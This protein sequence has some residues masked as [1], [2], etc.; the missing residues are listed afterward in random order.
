MTTADQNF[1]LPSAGQS[2]WDSDL[3]GNFTIIGRGYH[4]LGQ[5]GLDVDTGYIVTVGSDGFYRPYDPNSLDNRPHAYAYKAVDSGEQDTFLL[6]GMVRS[7]G[8]NTLGAI[9]GHIVFGSPTTPGMIV[10]SYSG[11]DRPAG[12]A[13]YEDGFFFDPGRQLFPEVIT[14][15]A[16]I[17]AVTGSLHLF[18]L[19]GGAAGFIRQIIMIGDSSDLTELQLWS[20]SA[21]SA[22]LYETVSG[23]VTVIGSFLDQAGLPFFNTDATTISGKVYG[24]LQ[25]MSDASV[26]SADVGLS[27]VF[28][29]FR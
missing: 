7:L 22:P 10:A 15:S 3:N 23:G 19:D 29:R 11:A 12:V 16:A 25:V 28:E 24:T 6:R 2:D 17:N 20:N 9:P 18:I 21:R 5:A 4:V 13:T 26:S 8:I 14:D 27:V 1:S